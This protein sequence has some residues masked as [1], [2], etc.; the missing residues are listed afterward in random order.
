MSDPENTTLPPTIVQQLRRDDSD[1]FLAAL[2]APAEV[3]HHLLTLYALDH[4]LK[5]IPHIVS[6][7]MLGAIR[8]QWWRD[9]IGAIYQGEAPGH[10]LVQPLSQAIAA[11]GLPPQAFHHWVDAREDEMSEL[12][13]EDL[14]TMS[15]HARRADGTIAELA[16]RLMAKDT[17]ATAAADFGSVYGLIDLM[18]RCGSAAG[19]RSAFLPSDILGDAQE[20]LFSGRLTPQVK[21][22]F[23]AVG[24]H[25][26]DLLKSAQE[27]KL[28]KQHLPAALHAGLVPGYV[29]MFSRADFDPLRTSPEIPAF[30]RQIALMARAVRGRI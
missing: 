9:T 7:P 28:P 8:F 19:R 14:H 25:A 12:P 6:E 27:T 5:R 4:E 17:D 24:Q 2:F 21:A 29:R 16:A 15:A 10:E 18:K 13:F 20:A 30:R 26:A 1:R 3:R 22:A 11:G 23:N